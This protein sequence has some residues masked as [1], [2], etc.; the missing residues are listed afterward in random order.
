MKTRI[1]S[2]SRLNL[3]GVS[4][5]TAALL[6]AGCATV[7]TAP[8]PSSPSAQPASAAA[9]PT[10]VAAAAAAP[11]AAASAP[12][13]APTPP[14]TPAPFAEVTRDAKRSAGYLSVWTRDDKTWLEIPVE[15]LN[16]P[17]FFAGSLASGLGE[18][19]FYPGLMG[20]EHVVVLHRVGNNVQDRK[21]VV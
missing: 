16:K 1:P 5:G 2:A 20:R 10:A 6:L 9:R 4:T 15:Q 11:G 17:F 14:A 19:F 18:R 8:A 12:A 7:G 13:R 3:A 21:S